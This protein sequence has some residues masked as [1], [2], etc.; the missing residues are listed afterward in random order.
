MSDSLRTMATIVM[1]L[2]LAAC[3]GGGGGGGDG[4]TIGGGGG[5]TST[6]YVLTVTG[7]EMTDTRTAQPVDAAGL[8]I[9]GA[10]ITR[11]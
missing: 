1:L 11:N 9:V 3:G 5:S 4:G 2:G 7:I 10:T 8:P 6:T